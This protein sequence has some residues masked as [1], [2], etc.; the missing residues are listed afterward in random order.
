MSEAQNYTALQEAKSRLQSA[1]EDIKRYDGA[2]GGDGE[3]GTFNGEVFSIIN[4]VFPNFLD[5]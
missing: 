2:I 4:E 5:Y 3:S 1:L